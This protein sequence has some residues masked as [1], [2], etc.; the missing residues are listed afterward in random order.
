MQAKPVAD[1]TT[2]TT[3]KPRF[4]YPALNTRME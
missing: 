3:E 2:L 4:N 1:G